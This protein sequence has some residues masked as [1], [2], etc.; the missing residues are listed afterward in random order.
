MHVIDVRQKCNGYIKYCFP[1]RLAFT[2]VLLSLI[3][4]IT[5][6]P[7]GPN[8][9]NIVK[10][11]ALFLEELSKHAL[12]FVQQHCMRL[13]VPLLARP[14]YQIRNAVL[15]CVAAICL[16]SCRPSTETEDEMEENSPASGVDDKL[17]NALLE[18][19]L[20]RHH[21]ISSYTRFRALKKLA[22][23]VEHNA[24]PVTM[25]LKVATVAT[26]RLKDKSS[27]V[28]KNSLAVSRRLD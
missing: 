20:E 22:E 24:M 5:A 11:S 17:R 12:D 2:D 19:L 14:A 18:L 8:D 16:K 9:A 21:D 4:E 6:M 27:L 25:L 1:A 13:L 23:L 28:R 7:F 26:D 10:Y 3:S 15:E